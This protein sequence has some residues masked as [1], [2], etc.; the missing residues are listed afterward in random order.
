MRFSPHTVLIPIVSSEAS[1]TTTTTTTT[2]LAP[3]TTYTLR[4]TPFAPLGVRPL[5]RGRSSPRV[6]PGQ[7]VYCPSDRSFCID[8]RFSDAGTCMSPSPVTVK[9][10]FDRSCRLS[11]A[12]DRVLAWKGEDSYCKE[13]MSSEGRVCHWAPEVP[14]TCESQ[15]IVYTDALVQFP[16]Q[17]VPVGYR[18]A[19]ECVYTDNYKDSRIVD[20]VGPQIRP[21]PRK[22]PAPV[23]ATADTDGDKEPSS[24]H[25]INQVIVIL[26]LAIV[27][28]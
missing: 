24:S 10:C 19:K 13:F 9:K 16:D 15:S 27:S 1:T 22:A 17:P 18:R 25:S 26:I 23:L 11:P 3:Y 8:T 7:T 28:V 12:N 2:T 20:P 14:C 4:L 5:R 21:P 6:F